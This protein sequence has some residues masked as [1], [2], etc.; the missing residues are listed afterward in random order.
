MK[1]LLFPLYIVAVLSGHY[2]F[3]QTFDIQGHR[4]CRGLMPENSIPG[5]IH[6]ID[7]GVTTLEM[8]VVISADGKVVVSHDPFI[9]GQFCVNE[10]G[11]EIKKKEEESINIYNM[12][13]EDVKLFDCGIIGNSSFPEQQKISVYKPLLSEV[14]EQCEAHIK[15]TGKAPVRYNIE[16]KSRPSWDLIYHPDPNLFTTLV[17]NVIEEKIPKERVCVQSFDL[18]ILHY[19]KMKYAEYAI[20]LL[21][22]N[23]KSAEKNIEELGFKPDIYSPHYKLVSSKDLDY[24]HD[25]SIKVIPWTINEANEMKK[26]I[27][28]GVDGLITDYP[29]RYFENIV[30]SQ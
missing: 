10:L 22:S 15:N 16:L 29:D 18:R 27:D 2:S 14:I 30:S 4:G 28:M 3:A 7:L 17:Y 21:V 23:N 1:R 25:L 20:S 8:D 5:F 6:A 26:V 19:W 24:L 9:S 13:Y 12:V 11:A